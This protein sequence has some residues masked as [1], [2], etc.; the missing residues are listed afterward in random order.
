MREQLDRYLAARADTPFGDVDSVSG[1]TLQSFSVA[2]QRASSNLLTK[3]ILALDDG[4]LER[5]RT[6]V[7]R[8]VRLPYDKHEQFH[9]AA[10][11]SHMMLFCLVT[12]ELEVADEDDSRW[13]DAAVAVLTTADEAGRCTMRD[14][15]LAI[16][17]DYHLGRAERAAVRSA[18]AS[19]PDRAEMRDLELPPAEMT[20]SVLSVLAACTDY[21]D[22]LGA[23]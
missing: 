22:A 2:G 20:D 1:R 4:N 19:V 5:A 14:V 23:C 21:R 7:D 6:Y 9:P 16:D 8:A 12:D 15:L 3:A 11:E 17:H 18:T 10:A 13:L